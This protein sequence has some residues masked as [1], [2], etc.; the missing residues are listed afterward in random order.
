VA[1]IDDAPEGAPRDARTRDT[2][3]TRDSGMADIQLLDGQGRPVLRL[4]AHGPVTLLPQPPGTYT[5]LVRRSGLT[6][7]HRFERPQHA[8]TGLVIGR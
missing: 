6:E 5:L 2:E 1:A 3:P 8:L 4:R 7:I